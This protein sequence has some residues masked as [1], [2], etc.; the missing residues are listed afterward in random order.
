MITLD[1]HMWQRSLGIERIGGYWY[2]ATL[3]V[4]NVPKFMAD[5]GIQPTLFM[6]DQS[7]PPRGFAFTIPVERIQP[8]VDLFDNG[9][10]RI[11]IF[12]YSYLN[13][14]LLGDHF[15]PAAAPPHFMLT[16]FPP[17][18][19]NTWKVS[20]PHPDAMPA[21][22]SGLFLKLATLIPYQ[23][24]LRLDD[25]FHES[26]YRDDPC[27]FEPSV[28]SRESLAG[29]VFRPSDRL[30]RRRYPKHYDPSDSPPRTFT[31]LRAFFTRL[32]RRR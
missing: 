12:L 16:V 30:R 27:P 31:R 13:Q 9:H 29:L 20:V 5:K 21:P 18:S 4:A 25:A 26:L 8:I 22:I 10:Q 17:D 7:T 28:P 6:L 24:H 2:A 19:D 23:Q 11:L 15:Y 3:L 32:F 1:D 14:S